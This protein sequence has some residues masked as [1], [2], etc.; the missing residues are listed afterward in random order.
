MSRLN[1]PYN[2]LQEFPVKNKVNLFQTG[3]VELASARNIMNTARRILKVQ[4]PHTTLALVGEG[5]N[6]IKLLFSDPKYGMIMWM[7]YIPATHRLDIH[8]PEGIVCV[9]EKKK[10]LQS[11]ASEALKRFGYED[12]F[13]QLVAL[14]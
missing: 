2:G 3:L 8:D 5:S 13:R 9:F 10:C 4:D 11:R 6:I 7:Y 12:L 14:T 1:F